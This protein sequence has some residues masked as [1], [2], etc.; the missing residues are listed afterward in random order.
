MFVYTDERDRITAYNAEEDLSH[1]SD[2]HKVKE[3][4]GDPIT[5]AFGVPLYKYQKGH[6]VS[7]TQEEIDADTPAPEEYQP[8]A[9]ELLQM[10]ID[11]QADA[12]IELAGL[13]GGE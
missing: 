1:N 9:I 10:Q 13:I 8:T 4:I 7:R 11:E 2:W 5:N 12:L 3:I 6:A